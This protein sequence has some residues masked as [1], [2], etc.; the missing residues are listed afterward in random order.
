MENIFFVKNKISCVHTYEEQGAKTVMCHMQNMVI[1]YGDVSQ[2]APGC[3]QTRSCHVS[4]PVDLAISPGR[5]D[6][7][8]GDK[9]A[10][11]CPQM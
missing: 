2:E 5:V 8:D 7:H 4:R 3:V 11:I 10:G 1:I 6:N 9:L